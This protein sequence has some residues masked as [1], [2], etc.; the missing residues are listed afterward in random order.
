MRYFLRKKQRSE[1]SLRCQYLYDV[2][3]LW[4]VPTGEIGDF[5]VFES[6]P[7]GND[8]LALIYGHNFE[9]VF[10]FERHSAALR[11]KN[12]AIISC[13]SDKPNG[14]FLKNKRVFLGP[15]RNGK[16]ELLIGAEYGFDFDITDAELRLYNCRIK[17]PLKKVLSVFVRIQ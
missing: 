7:R 16:A 17:D 5:D 12:L 14:Y 2:F 4:F 3:K 10:L 11:E 13:E 9:I 15:Q 1:I 6:I 8:D